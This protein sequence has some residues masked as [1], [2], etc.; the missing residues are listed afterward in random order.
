M[1]KV[2]IFDFG[3]RSSEF[4]IFI[5]IFIFSLKRIIITGPESSGKTTLAQK[6][7]LEFDTLF[8]PEYARIYLASKGTEYELT[9]IV[10]IGIGQ[11]AL[12][13]SLA[14][15]MTEKPFVFI[16]TWILEL[17]IW[18]KYR[19]GV[20]PDVLEEM[21]HEHPPDFYVLCSPDLAWQPDPLRENPQDR[22]VLFEIYQNTIIES[23]VPHFVISGTGER[24]DR[25]AFTL[26]RDWV[27][28]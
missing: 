26:F 3:S 19:F 15:T 14:S 25:R 6:L 21:Y 12:A 17:R 1:T 27:A 18:A 5:F 24:R 11:L 16:D 13:E 20:V 4:F 8:V 28:R 2:D 9:D 23:N 7:A 22:D 10:N